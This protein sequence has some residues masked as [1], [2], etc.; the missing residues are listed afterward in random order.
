MSPSSEQKCCRRKRKTHKPKINHHVCSQLTGLY[1][2]I[3]CKFSGHS[4]E[5][6]ENKEFFRMKL[7]H[8]RGSEGSTGGVCIERNKR[9][10]K[11]LCYSLSIVV[12]KWIS[13]T[14]GRQTNRGPFRDFNESGSCTKKSEESGLKRRDGLYRLTQAKEL[15][16][17]RETGGRLEGNDLETGR[18]KSSTAGWVWVRD[19]HVQ[20]IVGYPM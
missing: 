4:D 15:R 12:E 8:Y 7:G 14:T 19:R 9:V 20:R 16:T 10:S 1:G 11:E 3:L 17:K 5:F 18:S 13:E 2:G 6:I